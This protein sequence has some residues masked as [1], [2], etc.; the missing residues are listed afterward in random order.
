MKLA[1]SFLLA[2]TLLVVGFCTRLVRLKKNN[3]L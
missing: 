2:M 1:F 3:L